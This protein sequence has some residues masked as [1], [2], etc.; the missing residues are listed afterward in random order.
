MPSAPVTAQGDRACYQG[1]SGHHACA[2]CVRSLMLTS[3]RCNKIC[4]ERCVP[5]S[6]G[7]VQSRCCLVALLLPPS[8]WSLRL[9]SVALWSAA[10]ERSAWRTCQ[11]RRGRRQRCWWRDSAARGDAPRQQGRPL[12][13]VACAPQALLFHQQ[14][15]QTFALRMSIAMR[16]GWAGC[17]V[18]ALQLLQC[19]NAIKPC[20]TY[21]PTSHVTLTLWKGFLA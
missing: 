14:C 17:V 15:A 12:P 5:R 18:R 16:W 21:N 9:M 3:R 10:D 6:R 2:G 4:S 19:A 20:S 8:L 11:R 13:R 7:G 1:I